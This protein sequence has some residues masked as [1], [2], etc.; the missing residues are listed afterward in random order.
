[1]VLTEKEKTTIKDLQTQE[2]SCIEKYGKYACEAKD[3]V[4]K[5]LFNTLKAHEQEHYQS[6]G[7]VL[8]GNT[9]CYFMRG[10]YCRSKSHL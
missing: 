4:L 1:M 9:S 6:L 7:Q 2:Q 10:S 5:D 3:T 8:N